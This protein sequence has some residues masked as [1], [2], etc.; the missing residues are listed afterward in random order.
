MAV[1]QRVDA[2]TDALDRSSGFKAIKTLPL[3]LA[4]VV[5]GFETVLALGP[6]WRKHKGWIQPILDDKQ[7]MLARDFFV[8]RER[9]VQQSA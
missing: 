3:V 2:S 1:Q 9:F 5:F 7:P 4:A 6:Y 8:L